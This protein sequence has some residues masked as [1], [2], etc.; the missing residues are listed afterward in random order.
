MLYNQNF[1]WLFIV[2]EKKVILSI[3]YNHFKVY[4]SVKNLHVRRKDKKLSF[5]GNNQLT[6]RLL[7]SIG[8]R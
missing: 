7:I 1:V 8:D 4:K 2:R 6:F 3:F 5:S